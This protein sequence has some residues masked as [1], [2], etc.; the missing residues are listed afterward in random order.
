LCGAAFKLCDHSMDS[1]IDPPINSLS[2]CP[3]DR[4]DRRAKCCQHQLHAFPCL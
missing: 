1:V 3:T 2:S 4:H